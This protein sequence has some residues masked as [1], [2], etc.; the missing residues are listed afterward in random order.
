L[1]IPAK[2]GKEG[3]FHDPMGAG[4]REAN[5]GKLGEMVNADLIFRARRK[6]LFVVGMN[7]WRKLRRPAD[8]KG[9]EGK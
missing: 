8:G 3:Y 9:K 2:G 1:T 4:L 5:P 6:A 7:Y